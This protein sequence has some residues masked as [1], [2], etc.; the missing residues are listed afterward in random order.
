M[1]R[2]EAG[3]QSAWVMFDALPAGVCIADP[4]GRIAYANPSLHALLGRAP[5]ALA[6][7]DLAA[8]G[9]D[10]ADAGPSADGGHQRCFA[11]PDGTGVRLNEVAGPFTGPDGVTYALHVFTDAPRHRTAR[12]AVFR[13]AADA[14]AIAGVI[15]AMEDAPDD[16]RLDVILEQSPIGVSVS[17]RDT[18]II[19]FANTRF[20]ELVGLPRDRIVGSRARDYY[21]DDHQRGRVVEELKGSGSVLN[22]E[23]QFR[24]ADGSAF[25]TLFSVNQA[26]IQGVEVNLAWI[27]DYTERRNMEEALRDMAS[28]DPLTGIY[29]RRSFME[30]SRQALARSSRF[31]QPMSVLVLDVDHF[32]SVNDSFGHAVGDDALRAVAGACQ[33]ILREYDIL[34]RLGGEEFMVCLPGTTVDEARVVAERL[35]RYL[36][37]LGIAG[38]NGRFHVTVSIG[39]AGVEGGCDT[40]DQAIHRAD[41]ALYRA[42]REGRNRVVPY[43]PGM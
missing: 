24:R 12:K 9:W 27:Y 1:T 31:H 30:M 25:W 21:V 43:E 2:V 4:S 23:V 8:L 34:G 5:G 6:G 29:N 3:W 17:R 14:G 13:D 37:R 7:S 36:A 11:R 33:S 28:R 22:M 26:V 16:A 15:H 35:R 18:G 32:K 39:I 38:P 40:L 19:Q 41:L 42:K 20:A 10:A